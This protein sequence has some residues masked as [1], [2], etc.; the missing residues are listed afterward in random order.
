MEKLGRIQACAI[1]VVLIVGCGAA[2]VG[3]T[4]DGAASETADQEAEPGSAPEY[5]Q[6]VVTALAALAEQLGRPVDE[7]SIDSYEEAVWPDA[8]LG[9]A[10]K[11]E[12][13]AQVIVNGWRIAVQADDGSWDL[14][15]N[16]TG[17]Q[18]RWRPVEN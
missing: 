15:T 16:A 6:A 9:L 7:L 14:H 1:A 3:N 17:E 13:C 18:V 10:G 5:P 4:L 11:D 8:C 2:D 12:M